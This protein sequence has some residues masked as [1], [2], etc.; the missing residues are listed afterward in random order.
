MNNQNPEYLA[1][2]QS[3]TWHLKRHLRMIYAGHKCEICGNRKGLQAHHVTY[4]RLFHERISDLQ[5]LCENCHPIEDEKRRYQKGFE[6]YCIKRWG[7]MWPQIV[8]PEIAKGEFD[9]W[10][11][12]KK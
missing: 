11:E 12:S 4:E 3:F 1:Y 8:K 7:A 6:T 2:L 5:I 9:K 10:L